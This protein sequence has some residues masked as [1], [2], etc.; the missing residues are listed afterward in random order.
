MQ[1]TQR[2]AIIE[3]LDVWSPTWPRRVTRKQ[4]WTDNKP[5][6]VEQLISSQEENGNSPFISVYSFP[7]GHTKDNNIP[8]IDTL[9]IDFDFE[10]GDYESGSGNREAWFR[11]L[12]HLL[13]RVRR[14]AKFLRDNGRDGWRASLSGHKGVHLF[15]D[16]PRVDPVPEFQR[17]INGLSEY[18]DELIAQLSDATGMDDLER[19]VDVTS[20][21]MG[22]LCRVPNTLH[23]GATESFGEARFCVPIS[24]AELAEITPSKY[25]D[26]TQSPRE[27]PWESRTPN[28]DVGEIVTQ[29]IANTTERIQRNRTSAGSSVDWSR[30]EEYKEQSNDNI[31]L[32]DIEF[33]TSDRPC[34][35]RFYERDDKYQYSQQSHYMEMF[36]I[37]EMIEK[38]VPIEVM[39]E[40]F[41]SATEYNEDY[42]EHRIK[43]IISRDYNRFTIRGLLQN[44]PQFCGYDSCSL[45]Q[46]VINEHD[47][48]SN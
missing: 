19:Y 42:T 46:A 34:L 45:C 11:D 3:A 15:L 22:R 13:V 39:K 2:D 24:I 37:R 6:A 40:F 7:N 32:S 20:S 27:V 21:D 30:V 28:E 4:H 18:A 29:A 25:E 33:L 1:I 12:S 41:D 9:F 26:L 44:A 16:F 36:C 17:V 14:V 47:D 8:R 43:Q 10:G 5:F 31:D 38:N 23:G 48:L 35:W